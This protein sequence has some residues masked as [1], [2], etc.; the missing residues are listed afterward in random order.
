MP[1]PSASG[2]PGPPDA[3]ALLPER[4]RADLAETIALRRFGSAA[5]VAGLVASLLAPDAPDA[6]G[7]V[8]EIPNA[9]AL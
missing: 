9:L 7:R 5:D 2:P 4:H 6:T 3:A 1:A 8:L